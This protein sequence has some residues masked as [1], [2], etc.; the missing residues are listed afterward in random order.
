MIGENIRAARKAAGVSH[1]EV[2][3]IFS[4]RRAGK[5]TGSAG[6]E[7]EREKR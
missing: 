5:A 4:S 6:N 1:F 7:S 3:H 2:R